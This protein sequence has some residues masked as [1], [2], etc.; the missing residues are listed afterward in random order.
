MMALSFCF[1]QASDYYKE[2]NEKTSTVLN[3]RYDNTQ[4]LAKGSDGHAG[5]P[6]QACTCGETKFECKN[7]QKCDCVNNA[8]EN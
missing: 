2:S 6:K 8:C 3:D 5:N 1:V 7:D 4:L